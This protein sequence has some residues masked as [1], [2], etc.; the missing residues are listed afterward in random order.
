[1]LFRSNDT[2]TT[3][4][5]T[6]I[7]TL[8]LHD[9]LPS[10]ATAVGAFALPGCSTVA[11]TQLAVGPAASVSTEEPV[12]PFVCPGRSRSAPSHA[13]IAGPPKMRRTGTV[14][15]SDSLRDS[16]GSQESAMLMNASFCRS[17]TGFQHFPV[18][19]SLI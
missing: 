11:M 18:L 4:I 5:Y 14:A 7:D 3:E 8:S 6:S 13:D 19:S 16:P 15:K 10:F 9:A 17:F 12:L 2:A 1:M